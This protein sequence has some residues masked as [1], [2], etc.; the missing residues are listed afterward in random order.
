MGELDRWFAVFLA[1]VSAGHMPVH[2]ADLA[3]T[4]EKYYNAKKEEL[5]NA[6]EA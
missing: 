2:A 1:A 3:S 6:E 5:E 4:S